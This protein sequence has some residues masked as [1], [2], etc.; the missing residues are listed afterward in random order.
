MRFDNF[1]PI[2]V[3]LPMPQAQQ[4]SIPHRMAAVHRSDHL[5]LRWTLSQVWTI[6]RLAKAGHSPR[7]IAELMLTTER[8]IRELC[9]RNSIHLATKG[10]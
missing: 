6:E 2:G 7:E 1:V 9:A 10:G 4:Q 3:V 8:E 5:N